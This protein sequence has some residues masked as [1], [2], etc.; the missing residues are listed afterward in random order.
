MQSPGSS[1]DGFG[2]DTVE[3]ESN[4]SACFDG[5]PQGYGLGVPWV[6]RDEQADQDR[7]VNDDV[8][9]SHLIV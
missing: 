9:R 8:H 4:V 6:V 2:G 7:G 1:A 3:K 5:L